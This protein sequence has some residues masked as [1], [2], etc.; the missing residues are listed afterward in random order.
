MTCSEVDVLNK[1]LSLKEL[2]TIHMKFALVVII[3]VLLW[4]SNDARQFTAD[5]LDNAA[6]FVRPEP[7]SLKQQFESL[8]N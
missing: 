8:F 6:E 4:N 5:A 3:G 7:K 2:R 1:T